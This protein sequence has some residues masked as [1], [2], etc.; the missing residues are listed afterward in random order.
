M[1]YVNNTDAFS[2]FHLNILVLKTTLY[3]GV[4]GWITR[5]FASWNANLFSL[6]F[7]Y[8]KFLK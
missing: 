6:M 3:D 7:V 5:Q 4:F 2:P 8:I 1:R